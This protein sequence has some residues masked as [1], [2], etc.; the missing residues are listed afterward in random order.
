VGC[1]RNLGCL[2]L[3]LLVAV[4]GYLTRDRWLPLLGYEKKV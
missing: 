4:V 1:L 3:L 2:F